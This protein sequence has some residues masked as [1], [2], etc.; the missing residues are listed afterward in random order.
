MLQCCAFLG[1][2]PTD[3]CRNSGITPFNNNLTFC[4]V[5]IKKSKETK[6][7]RFID[8]IKKHVGSNQRS[9]NDDDVCPICYENIDNKDS[10]VLDCKHAF[11][12]S[13]YLK[14]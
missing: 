5:H 4:G 1:S 8:N 7:T 10:I 3:L 12:C 6:E 13:I 9:E 14:S 11:H 2:R